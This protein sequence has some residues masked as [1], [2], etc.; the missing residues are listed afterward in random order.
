MNKVIQFDG[1]TPSRVVATVGLEFGKKLKNYEQ[2]NNN[3]T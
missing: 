1:R 2:V 3:T